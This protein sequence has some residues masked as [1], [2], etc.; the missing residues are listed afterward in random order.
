MPRCYIVKKQ[1][2]PAVS[3]AYRNRTAATGTTAVVPAKTGNH[4]HQQQQ[5]QHQTTARQVLAVNGKATAHGK[6]V[7]AATVRNGSRVRVVTRAKGGGCSSNSSS[8][9]S[10]LGNVIVKS[11]SVTVG[12]ETTGS[13]AGAGGANGSNLVILNS[14]SVIS[15]GPGA[16]SAVV[17]DGGKGKVSESAGVVGFTLANAGGVGGGGVG[18]GGGSGG[19]IV[20]RKDDSSGPVSPTEGCVAPIYYTNISENKSAV[21]AQTE[22]PTDDANEENPPQQFSSLTGRTV[23]SRCCH[24]LV[25]VVR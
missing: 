1:Q 11:N 4:H 18:A 9:S 8:S 15:G 3:S 12:K 22:S 16:G 7:E 23:K 6:Q 17:I 5:Q 25:A 19:G 10:A 14:V 20:Q 2:P 13:G 21:H 24:R